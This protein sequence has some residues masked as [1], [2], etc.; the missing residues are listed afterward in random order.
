MKASQAYREISHKIDFGSVK[1]EDCFQLAADIR[2][3]SRDL[4]EAETKKLVDKIGRN[5]TPDQK[6]EVVEAFLFSSLVNWCY[7]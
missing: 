5:L 1:K 3:Y 2:L 6:N 7:D 4:G